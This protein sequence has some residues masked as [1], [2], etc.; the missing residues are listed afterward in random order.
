MALL[1]EDRS[2]VDLE[3]PVACAKGTLIDEGT[4]ALLGGG[5]LKAPRGMPDDFI[6][7]DSPEADEPPPARLTSRRTV[8]CV[9]SGCAAVMLVGLALA[10]IAVYWSRGFAMARGKSQ[11]A[12]ELEQRIR[13]TSQGKLPKIRDIVSHPFLEEN[14][15]KEIKGKWCEAVE[16]DPHYGVIDFSDICPAREM[17]I[18]T[19]DLVLQDGEAIPMVSPELTEKQFSNVR[20]YLL[21]NSFR[22]DNLRN[23][24]ALRALQGLSK[25]RVQD[26]F[27]FR[28]TWSDADTELLRKLDPTA[29]AWT[30]GNLTT[31]G[32]RERLPRL[33]DFHRL[34]LE[35]SI[36][37]V[38]GGDSLSEAGLGPE[39]DSHR[40]VAR[41]N[42]I[43]G[44]KLVPQ[45]TGEKTTIH[46]V[47]S[48]VAP[49]GDPNVAE[50]DLETDTVWRTYCGRMHTFGEF[51][52]VT[53]KPFLIRPSAHCTLSRHGA[54]K[55]TR[56]FLFYWFIGRLFKG[57][58][59]YGFSGTGHYHNPDPIY[60]HNLGFEHLF[61][62]VNGL[63][64]D[65]EDEED[66]A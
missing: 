1:A 13:A 23:W 15:R 10:A 40:T 46:I 58:D 9:T 44:R 28:E 26:I 30:S 60:E 14:L 52:D 19:D 54:K 64:L 4:A 3:D 35:D 12:L 65:E 16:L 66:G 47:N 62:R 41:F 11:G 57:V 2:Q 5:C 29:W 61:Y 50:F 59:M 48:K 18:S 51:A 37:I 27:A 56:G 38:G 39:I 22:G 34:V 45:E 17:D 7:S 53:E 32:F 6:D 33:E 36:A 8:T 49:V 63:V 25:F 21:Y 31:E 20:N 43:V 55:W 42:E 24:A